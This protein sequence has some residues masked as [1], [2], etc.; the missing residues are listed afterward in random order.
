MDD[1]KQISDLFWKFHNDRLED[2][3]VKEMKPYIDPILARIERKV[4]EALLAEYKKNRRWFERMA[5]YAD[6]KQDAMD[7][8][9]SRIKELST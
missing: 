5:E 8:Y 7:E 4:K 1:I 9:D 2:P 3:S 6:V